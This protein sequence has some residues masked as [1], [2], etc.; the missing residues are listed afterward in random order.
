MRGNRGQAFVEYLLFIAL[1][2]GVVVG[3][4][5]PLFER[6]MARYQERILSSGQSVVSQQRMGIP[7][8]WFFGSG[9]SADDINARLAAAGDSVQTPIDS[10]GGPSSGGGPG[11]NPEGTGAGDGGDDGGEGAGG[12]PGGGGGRGPGRRSGGGGAGSG[13][14]SGSGGDGE[15]S[16]QG[17]GPG[18]AR[19]KS[20]QVGGPEGGVGSADR[21]RA[22]QDPSLAGGET[23]PEGAEGG[24]EAARKG[25]RFEDQTRV[26]QGGC[27]SMDFFTLFKLIAVIAILL[28]LGGLA[29][30]NRGNRKK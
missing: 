7:F 26:A 12:G 30:T 6:N 29:L 23:G 18:G 20:A 19:A 13:G 3:V 11:A 4:L 21:D 8:G 2:V 1:A 9:L 28:L 22:G 16:E 24:D 27:R 17:P 14:A 25:R 15:A 10:T 5:Y